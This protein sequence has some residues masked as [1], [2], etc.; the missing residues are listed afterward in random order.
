MK[1]ETVILTHPDLHN[2]FRYGAVV[3]IFFNTRLPQ[4]GTNNVKLYF[5]KE[6]SQT[7]GRI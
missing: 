3:I 6:E 4:F 5:E 1:Y 2:F 7:G